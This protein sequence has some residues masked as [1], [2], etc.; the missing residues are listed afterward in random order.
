MPS[1]LTTSDAM[2]SALSNRPAVEAALGD[3]G[4]WQLTEV[5]DGNMNSVFRVA[6][7]SGSVIAKHA[8]PYIR[9][10][11]EGWPFPQSRLD[12]EH[13]ALIEHGRICPNFVP[14]VLDYDD[15]LPLLVLEDLREH[16]VA[17]QALIDAT[18]LPLLGQHMGQFLAL[19]LFHTSDLA[20]DTT[21]KKAL[22]SRFAGNAELCATTEEVIFNGPYWSAPLN[23]W[24]DQLKSLVET[25]H[26]DRDL[27]FEAS[28][29]NYAFRTKTQALIHGD[30]HTGSV[31]VTADDT[32][33]IDHEWA[34][35]GPMGFDIGAII[36]NLLIAHFAQA[37]HGATNR[38]GQAVNRNAYTQDILTMISDLWLT[39]TAEFRRLAHAARDMSD[40]ALLTPR[41]FD[42]QLTDRFLDEYLAAVLLDTAG[43][44]G[45]K[46]TRRVIGIS[47][48][49]D[50]ELIE[51][52]A[53]RAI[54]ERQVLK[55]ARGLILNRGWLRSIDDLIDLATGSATTST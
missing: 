16:R 21:D 3:P 9:V 41:L 47:H 27:H 53:T 6:G 22:V 12:F 15:Q 33:V 48:V 45:A 40:R 5:S 13:A 11:G 30:L 28:K 39:F 51:D 38:K 17:R 36:G 31:M 29:L 43:F 1:L 26:G 14:A 25:W 32:R 49:E 4:Q 19:S 23:R 54:H 24:N 18:P 10:I 7:P 8:P 46:M 2:R 50:L 35:H 20:L 52:P 37:G 34:F 55:A 44:A 42:E